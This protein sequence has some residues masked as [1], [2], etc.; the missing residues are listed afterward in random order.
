[1]FKGSSTKTLKGKERKG[2]EKGKGKGIE[3]T[4]ELP[5]AIINEHYYATA[6]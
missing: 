1:M 4:S 2:K 3:M 6:S 5:D